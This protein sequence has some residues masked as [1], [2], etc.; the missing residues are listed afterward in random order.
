MERN[1][2]ASVIPFSGTYFHTID[3]K[4]RV[5]IPRKLRELI[6][7][8]VEGEG[9]FLTKGMA[10]CLVL[11]TP[12]QWQTL[13]DKLREASPRGQESQD[14]LRIFYGSAERVKSDQQGRIVIP[15]ALREL[16]ELK[17]DVTFVGV[18]NR[19]EMWDSQI[20]KERLARTLAAYEE[21]A[22]QVLP[23]L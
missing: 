16:A 18:G 8:D 14:F 13:A 17:R 20:H 11:Y 12:K 22:S 15:E 2:E 5:I 4:S 6:D 23:G 3:E 10:K 9:F 7:T 21:V 1:G 19:I